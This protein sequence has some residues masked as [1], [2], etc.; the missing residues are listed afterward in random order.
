MSAG[1]VWTVILGLAVITYCIRFSFMGLLAG[2][3]VPEWVARP[4]RYVP[5]AVLPALAAPM[6]LLERDTGALTAPIQW[7]AAAAAVL[8]GAL[9]RNMLLTIVVGLGVFHLGRLAGL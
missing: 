4:L 1:Y 3:T 5:S 8:V 6:V 7:L 2:R 9:S